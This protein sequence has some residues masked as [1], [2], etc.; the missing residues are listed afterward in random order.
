MAATYDLKKTANGK[1]MFNLKAANG[2]VILTSESYETKEKALAGIESVRTNSGIDGRYERR[3][4]G[5]Q[6]AFA[7]KAANGETIGRSELYKTE[8]S[9]ETGIESVKVNGG[10]AQLRDNTLSA[11]KGA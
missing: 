10:K 4:S 2:G 3:V 9:R 8:A 5:A 7:L 6:F 1:F 11:A